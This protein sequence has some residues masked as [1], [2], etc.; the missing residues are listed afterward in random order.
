VVHASVPGDLLPAVLSFDVA[1]WYR[2]V[3]SGACHS[4]R[5]RVWGIPPV[6]QLTFSHHKIEHDEN[7]LCNPYFASELTS[8]T[9]P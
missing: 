2:D 4:S 1:F 9:R 6:E 3:C 7:E 5:R 8:Q